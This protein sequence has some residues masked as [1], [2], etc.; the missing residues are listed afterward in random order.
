MRAMSKLLDK[1]DA[2]RL[3]KI[4]IPTLDRLRKRTDFPRPL[5]ISAHKLAF[6]EHDLEAWIMAQR[7][8]VRA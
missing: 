3:L 8:D 1:M 5:R 7:E 4:S 6:H 2:A